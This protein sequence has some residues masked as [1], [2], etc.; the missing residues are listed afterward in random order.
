MIQPTENSRPSYC[1][2][3]TLAVSSGVVDKMWGW[4]T[5]SVAFGQKLPKLKIA[6]LCVMV[7]TETICW[8]NCISRNTCSIVN[9]VLQWTTMSGTVTLVGGLTVSIICQRLT[10]TSHVQSLRDDGNRV[11]HQDSKR[12][13]HNYHTINR[14]VNK[15]MGTLGNCETTPCS[16]AKNG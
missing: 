3:I 6:C 12:R 4:N 14:S 5:S 15:K 7:Q 11:P 16:L 2:N 1:H 9:E 13:M 8:N 10:I